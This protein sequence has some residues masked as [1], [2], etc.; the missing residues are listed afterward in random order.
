MQT[1]RRSS[2]RITLP[3]QQAF[4]E[5]ASLRQSATLHTL[6]AAGGALAF[7][8]QTP[9]A[10]GRTVW[11]FALGT[12]LPFLAEI[13]LLGPASRSEG[14][15]LLAFRFQD[16][17][18]DAIATLSAY[19]CETHALHDARRERLFSTDDHSIQV[20]ASANTPTRSVASPATIL[21][22]IRHYVVDEKVPLF[23]YRGVR[24]A[25]L[26]LT[27]IALEVR[28]DD[29]RLLAG[30]LD[31][32][33]DGLAD[34]DD[35]VF[36]YATPLAVTWFRSRLDQVSRAGIV[37]AASRTMFQTG[38]RH[39]RRVS[40]PWSHPLT[41]TVEDPRLCGERI[42]GT[43]R[44]IAGNGFS[45]ELDRNENHL[46]PGQQLRHVSIDFPLGAVVMECVLRVCRPATTTD[47]RIVGGF[48]VVR[49]RAPEDHDRWMRSV[50][51]CIFPEVRLGDEAMVATAWRR[52]E[53]SGYLDLIDR[54]ERLR[55][56]APFFEDWT[57]HAAD[58]AFRA[59]LLVSY[60]E[61]EPVG[62]A[63]GNLV[64]PKTCL[65]HSGG[66]DK[67][68]QR[69]GRVLQLAAASFLFAD[70]VADYTLMF[71]EADKP[72]NVVLFRR[73]VEQYTARQDHLFDSLTVY[74]W[75]ACTPALPGP[76]ELAREVEV[77]SS[78]PDLL[79][80]LWEHQRQTLSPLELDAYGWSSDNSA[81]RQFSDGCARHGYER[82]RHVFF[83]LHAGAPVAALIAETGSEGMNVF[84]LLN[85][86][87]VVFFKG[88][89]RSKTSA[90]RALLVRA[91]DFYNGARKGAFLF[92]DFAGFA[93]E[94]SLHDVGFAHVAEGWRWLASK[95]VIP[96]YISYLQDL[97][98]VREPD[99]RR[100]LS[101]PTAQQP[102]QLEGGR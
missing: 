85:T 90:L 77:V 21:A 10:P 24:R 48:E 34:A 12:H 68:A 87:T 62:V 64:Y 45:M 35:H 52:L 93:A 8:P 67:Q 84:S 6:N 28:G 39:S 38:F 49:F 100:T 42:V 44:E 20:D 53:Q 91:V 92:L 95:R 86:C 16:L 36:F 51:P 37:I 96:A 43:V 81:M 29:W 26:P 9:P 13:A 22:L 56:R 3:A 69:S 57:C 79:R 97:A 83:A 27:D 75:Q 78:T 31:A 70:A 33:L 88:A 74:R 14:E 4:A 60:Q 1:E 54:P 17:G 80:L 7:G 58:S 11:R 102:S 98:T 66:V 71:F 101:V 2:Y 63:A 50:L 59:R 46:F 61:G 47:A 23:L 15:G 94:A 89:A 19:L 41:A 5:S 18:A 25:A 55:L 32:D 30:G 73:F 82:Q 76:P 65:I 99:A 72:I 40:P